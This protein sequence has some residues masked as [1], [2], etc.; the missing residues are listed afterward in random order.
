MSHFVCRITPRLLILLIACSGCRLWT[1]E[2]LPLPIRD[3]LSPDMLAAMRQQ[4]DRDDWRPNPEWAPLEVTFEEAT[5][6]RLFKANRWI[7]GSRAVDDAVNRLDSAAPTSTDTATPKDPAATEVAG[8]PD[9]DS[10]QQTERRWD[11]FWPLNVEQ[12]VDSLDVGQRSHSTRLGSGGLGREYLRRLATE[13]NLSG[14]NAAILLAQRDPASARE[15]LPVLQQLVDSYPRQTKS[16]SFNETSPPKTHHGDDQQS[17]DESEQAATDGESIEALV[18][19]VTQQLTE[20]LNRTKPPLSPEN[21]PAKKPPQS[22]S[23]KLV[24]SVLER[25]QSLTPSGESDGKQD[26]PGNISESMRD[27]AVEAW[28]LVLATS[29]DDPLQSLAPAGKMLERADLPNRIR[30]ELY[31]SLAIHISPALLPRLSN[32]LRVAGDGERVLLPVR[33]AAAESCLIHAFA[34]RATDKAGSPDSQASNNTYDSSRWPPTIINCRSDRDGTIR[35]IFGR[36]AAIAGYEGDEAD[37]ASILEDQLNDRLSQVRSDALI[38]LGWLGTAEA[39]ATLKDQSQRPEPLVRAAA[40]SGLA[41]WGTDE[42]AP[43]IADESS[44]VRQAVARQFAADPS[45]RSFF[46]IRELLSDA[47]LQVQ[48]AAVRTIANWPDDPALTLLL[49]AL[50]DG[51]APTRRIAFEEIRRRR[52]VGEAFATFDSPHREQREKAVAELGTRLDITLH[53]SNR[54]ELASIKL[55]HETDEVF[56][57]DVESLLLTVTDRS[58]SANSP[59]RAAAVERLLQLR[60]ADVPL[61]ENFVMKNAGR[62][63]LFVLREL[64]PQLSPAHAALRDLDEPELSKKRYAAQQ[65]RQSAATASLSPLMLQR[66]LPHLHGR[67]DMLIWRDAMTAVMHD[68]TDGNAQVALRALNDERGDIRKLGCDFILRHPQPKFATWL[69]QLKLFNDA[70]KRV[71]LAAIEAAGQCGNPTV[72]ADQFDTANPAEQPAETKTRVPGLRSLLTHSDTDTRIRTVISMAQL[73]DRQGME[74]LARL[75]WSPEHGTRQIAVQA[76]GKTNSTWFIEP[77]IRRGWTERHVDV[78]RAILN[79][80]NQLTLPGKRPANLLDE[81]GYDVKIKAWLEWWEAGRQ[82]RNG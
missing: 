32:A 41:R 13:N 51:S 65:L 43:F 30:G 49:I 73:G 47:D 76:M 36:W 3:T 2:P 59:Q 46:L 4:L 28:C 69:Q 14:W 40:V 7:F 74:E 72:L 26:D 50:R 48:S 10:D 15:F 8:H 78:R 25:V 45:T 37:A 71:R 20:E 16:E 57:R 42:L 38:S 55:H 23:A 9:T 1:V 68:A 5:S 53:F 22:Q 63:D 6:R 34:N 70:D 18:E 67:Q 82:T 19:R 11:G 61:I 12:V 77:L 58:L 64:L 24:E 62:D 80:L 66:L 79:S 21:Q 44:L 54:F 75:S 17:Q 60:P 27:A 52:T 56:E 33:R 31:R 39:L 29:G 81:S 35:R